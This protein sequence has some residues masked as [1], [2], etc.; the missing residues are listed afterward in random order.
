MFRQEFGSITNQQT[1]QLLCND[2]FVN[3]RVFT[4]EIAEGAFVS[5]ASHV[6]SGSLGL[7]GQANR[8]IRRIRLFCERQDGESINFS[9]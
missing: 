1:F 2:V 4:G 7:A 6:K 5:Y 9:L 8:R 3:T